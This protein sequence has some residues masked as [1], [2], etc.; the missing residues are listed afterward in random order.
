M[1]L[2]ASNNY[3]VVL[4]CHGTCI[5]TWHQG[6]HPLMIFKCMV[7]TDIT[8]QHWECCDNHYAKEGGKQVYN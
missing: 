7:E 5:A 4:Y 2:V 8:V 1:L 6:P 3:N